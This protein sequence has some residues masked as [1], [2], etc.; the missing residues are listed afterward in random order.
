MPFSLAFQLLDLY[1]QSVGHLLSQCASVTFSRMT[2]A[3]REMLSLRSVIM[4]SGNNGSG[5]RQVSLGIRCA[6][7][8]G[9]RSPCGGARRSGTTSANSRRPDID[10]QRFEQRFLA[11]MHLVDLV[12]QCDHWRVDSPE[13]F[14]HVLVFRSPAVQG[15][16][17]W[18]RNVRPATGRG[19]GGQCDWL[20]LGQIKGDEITRIVDLEVEAVGVP[21][22]PAC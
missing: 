11:G 4:S 2:S 3:I 20:L 10:G 18:N 14:E 19:S 5:F 6:A 21:R 13:A 22:R 7:R 12:K 16:P 8:F 9:R 1:G 17:R 15:C